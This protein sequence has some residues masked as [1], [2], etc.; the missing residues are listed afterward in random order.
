MRAGRGVATRRT[1]V[2]AALDL[3][4][5]KGVEETAVDE[6]TSAANV[7]K[8][9]FYVHFQRKQD[10]LLEWAAE[11]VEAIDSSALPDDDAPAALRALGQQVAARMEEGPRRLVGRVVREMVGN[12]GDWYRVLGDR[13]TLWSRIIPIVER[14]QAAGTIRTDMSP[15]R[16]SMALTIL[17]LDNVVGW[18]ERENPRPLP[19]AVALSTDLFLGG[20]QTP[21]AERAEG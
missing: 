9:T 18:A 11:L 12:S 16:L 17:W 4:A 8:G 6:I 20:A 19:D 1:L 13:E 7:A 3:F 21:V 14:G 10:V 15:L 2:R 5:D